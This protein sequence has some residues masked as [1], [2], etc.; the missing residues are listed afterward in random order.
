M[1]QSP[2]NFEFPWAPLAIR[3]ELRVAYLA[4]LEFLTTLQQSTIDFSQLAGGEEGLRKV[5]CKC[6][7]SDKWLDQILLSL[8]PHQC[9][10]NPFYT[11]WI[12]HLLI[13]F[14]SHTVSLRWSVQPHNIYWHGPFSLKPR[15]FPGHWLHELLASTFFVQDRVPI[16]KIKADFA[17][18]CNSESR[19]YD[20][21]LNLQGCRDCFCLVL[22]IIL[23]HMA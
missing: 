20:S 7:R 4:L 6:A 16:L 14:S 1:S 12:R 22:K 2:G 11:P 3:V 5:I 8:E 17:K 23:H 18:R 9:E 10:V 19:N 15:L 21:S 13:P